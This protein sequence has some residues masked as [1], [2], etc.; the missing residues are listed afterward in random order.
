MRLSRSSG[1]VD[2]RRD[3]WDLVLAN[4]SAAKRIASTVSKRWEPMRSMALACFESPTPAVR[5]LLFVI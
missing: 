5:N 3:G 2:R 1:G 4:T